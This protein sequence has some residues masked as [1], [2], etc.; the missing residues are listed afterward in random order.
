MFLDILH[1][2]LYI[3]FYILNQFRLRSAVSMGSHIAQYA[4]TVPRI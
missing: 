2:K 1:F 4:L 3:I